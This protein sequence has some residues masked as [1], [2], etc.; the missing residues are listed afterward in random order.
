MVD[1]IGSERFDCWTG[2]DK[3]LVRAKTRRD[4]TGKKITARKV[5]IRA[6]DIRKYN[7]QSLTG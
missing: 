4:N 3:D 6:A 5:E 7:Y 1:K 2:R